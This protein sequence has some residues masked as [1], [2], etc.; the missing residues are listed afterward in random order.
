MTNN[1]N[2]IR[3]GRAFVELFADD[4][5]LARG[6]R[7]AE[8]R[9][10]GWGKNVAKIGGVIM[11][12]GLAVLTPLSLA[13]KTFADFGDSIAKASDRTGVAIETLSEYAYA[14]GQSGANLEIFEG[15]LRKMQKFLVEGAKGGEA[16]IETLRRLG[17]T[18]Q[19]LNGLTP[20]QQFE[21]IADRLA[22][23]ESP[24]LRA[25]LA[26]EVFGKTGT[27]LLPLIKD[28]AKGIQALREEARRLGL[29][30]SEDDARAAEVLGD[31]WA[32]LG[33]IWKAT[34]VSIGAALAPALTDLLKEMI[35]LA[36]TASQWIKQNREL[37]V[38]L[39]KGGVIVL[40]LGAGILALGAALIA[41]GA[42]A[43]GFLALLA[44]VKATLVA[45]GAFVAF[46]ASFA[47]PAVLMVGAIGAMTGAFVAFGLKAS[48]AM[49]GFGAVF[50]GVFSGVMDALLSGNMELAFG[51]MLGGL[52]LAA[53]KAELQ[54]RE[55]LGLKTG[56][57]KAMVMGLEAGVNGLRAVAKA[58][59]DAFRNKVFGGA[60]KKGPTDDFNSD[61]A[62]MLARSQRR[63]AVQGT[64]NPFAAGRMSQ[65]PQVMGLLKQQLAVQKKIEQ[66]TKRDKDGNRVVGP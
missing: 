36:L 55:M 41:A 49:Q 50:K 28:G 4:T 2:S 26:M 21:R 54:F 64:F 20:D 45:L 57:T 35:G 3:A 62:S 32:D 6:L 27:T 43:G 66:N 12:M 61:L 15:S 31:R 11:G 44:A 37:F 60:A 34:K 42:A 38:L 14:A 30:I 24:A 58:E 5:K 10:Q 16:S 25:A 48:G 29:T 39:A 9:L 13:V 63:I 23:I 65:S 46:A 19:D 18:I 53:M 33:K 8:K 7:A 40:A 56:A 52:Q 1:A 17:L 59:A 22:K 51:T 47:T